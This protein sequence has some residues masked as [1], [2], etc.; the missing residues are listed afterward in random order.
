LLL[1]LHVRRR[2]HARL[3]LLR[4]L[5]LLLLLLLWRLRLLRGLLLLRLLLLLLLGLLNSWMLLLLWRHSWLLLL[6]LLML[7]A[8]RSLVRLGNDDMLLVLYVLVHH[9]IAQRS[10]LRCIHS[11]NS[12]YTSRHIEGVHVLWL[13]VWL[14]SAWIV[15]RLSSLTIGRCL[16]HCSTGVA[17]IICRIE[18]LLRLCVVLEH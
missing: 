16:L 5:R 14:H 9:W 1:L 17:P 8:R 10:L 3:L 11:R 4:R 12:R 7:H 18:N 15:A 13:V 6:M 2:R